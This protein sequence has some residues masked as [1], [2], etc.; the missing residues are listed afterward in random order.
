MLYRATGTVAIQPQGKDETMKD[1]RIEVTVKGYMG[2]KWTLCHFEKTHEGVSEADARALVNAMAE[3]EPPYRPEH[4][5][6]A[7]VP[8]PD[9]FTAERIMPGDILEV[10][11]YTDSRVKG[12]D[13]EYNAQGMLSIWRRVADFEHR[14]EAQ[15]RRY[16]VAYFNSNA[17]KGTTD[18]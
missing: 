9:T 5:V 8:A 1:C 17:P 11:R 12:I 4:P 3:L 16:A 14:T 2:G 10:H 18:E 15:A 7:P 13:I 6:P